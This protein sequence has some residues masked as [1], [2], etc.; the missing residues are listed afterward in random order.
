[1]LENIIDRRT[2]PYTT[3]IDAAFQP[4]V[5]KEAGNFAYDEEFGTT[6]AEACK[7]AQ[8]KWDCKVTV[9]LYDVGSIEHDEGATIKVVT[10][11]AGMF[12]A[13]TINKQA[14]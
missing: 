13:V 6:V 4:T 9:Y 1:M 7:M 10:G 2:N 11:K 12:D 8:V 5:P 3:R 14:T